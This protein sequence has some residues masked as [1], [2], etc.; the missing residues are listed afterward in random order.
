MQSSVVGASTMTRGELRVVRLL[1]TLASSSRMACTSGSRYASVLP[2]P[3]AQKPQSTHKGSKS[4][5]PGATSDPKCLARK[6]CRLHL[7]VQESLLQDVRVTGH[8]LRNSAPTCHKCYAGAQHLPAWSAS[9][10]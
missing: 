10:T 5:I 4:L 6:Q 2:L 9:T 1:Q 3:A 7:H 8:E